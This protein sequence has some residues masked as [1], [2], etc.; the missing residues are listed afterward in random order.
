VM[1]EL[2]GAGFSDFYRVALSLDHGVT[3][4]APVTAESLFTNF[5]TGAPGFNRPSS[6]DFAGLS[7][8]RS[9]GPNRGRFYLSWGESIDW[10]DEVFNL[11]QAG[12][13][14]EVEGNNGPAIA[15]PVTAGQ[16]IRGAIPDL[17]D[18]DYYAIP[19]A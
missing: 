3:F 10:L 13:K 1:Y 18:V 11:G 14:S 16:T 7:V 19:L 9:H 5:G 8:D 17:T 2:I 12:S 15:T 6:V 4:T